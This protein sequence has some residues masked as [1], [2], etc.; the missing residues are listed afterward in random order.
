MVVVLVTLQVLPPQLTVKLAEGPP[1]DDAVTATCVVF[2]P[3]AP[4]L[5]VAVSLTE[6][7]PAAEKLCGVALAG[8]A[9]ALL[10]APL[11]GSPKSQATD[12]MDPSASLLA[13]VKVQARSEQSTRKLAV[14]AVFDGPLL[15]P[16]QAASQATP[17]TRVRTREE[18]IVLVPSP[19]M[20]CG[21]AWEHGRDT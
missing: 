17:A 15:S 11:L 12:L 21:V 6:Y 5:S 19:R 3:V 8:P 7:V 1:G 2:V 14:G 20:K 4:P 9:V 16:P 18:R 10:A 13:S